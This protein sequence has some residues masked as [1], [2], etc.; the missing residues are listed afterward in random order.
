MKILNI[1]SYYI[2]QVFTKRAVCLCCQ[3]LEVSHGTY[4]DKNEFLQL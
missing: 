4:A 3:A 1:T 2:G